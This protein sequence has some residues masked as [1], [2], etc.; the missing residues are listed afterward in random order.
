MT[1]QAERVKAKKKRTP[2][3]LS[4]CSATTAAAVPMP[5]LPIQAKTLI[6]IKRAMGE[7][8]LGVGEEDKEEEPATDTT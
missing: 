3:R 5:M 7:R 4:S 6:A 1:E 8:F 2:N